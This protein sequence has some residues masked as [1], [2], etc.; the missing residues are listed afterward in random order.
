MNAKMPKNGSAAYVSDAGTP[1]ISD[2]GFRLV[3]AAVEQGIQI[4]PIPGASAL[5]ALVSVAG[6][7]VDSFTFHGFLPHKKGRQ[8]LLKSFEDAKISQI[9]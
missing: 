4:I 6:V 3:R 2:P 1:W 8:T 7:P 5:T 9:F